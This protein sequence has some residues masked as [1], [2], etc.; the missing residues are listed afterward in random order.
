MR[1]EVKR[2]S[3]DARHASLLYSGDK[4]AGML[5]Q[6][7]R[8]Q[9]PPAPPSAS[10]FAAIAWPS[11]KSGNHASGRPGE[12]ARLHIGVKNPTVIRS[13]MTTCARLREMLA[14]A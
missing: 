8:K 7:E 12:N 3:G 10:L 13:M 5:N 4:R 11:R 2:S 6:A 1:S 14:T 9:A